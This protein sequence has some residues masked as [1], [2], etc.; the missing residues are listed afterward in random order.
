MY[1]QFVQEQQQNITKN[2]KVS[3]TNTRSVLF[4][5]ILFAYYH[6]K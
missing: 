6:Y 5:F 4:Y 1:T 2:N 3:L